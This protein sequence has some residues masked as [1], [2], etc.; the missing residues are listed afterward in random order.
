MNKE[1][2]YNKVIEVLVDKLGIED[3]EIT[4][5][6]KL[7]NDLGADSLNAIGILMEFELFYNISI[8]DD[9]MNKIVTVDDIVNHLILTI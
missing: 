4:G 2:I 9:V 8:P 7:T 1:E 3:V 5:K 6:S